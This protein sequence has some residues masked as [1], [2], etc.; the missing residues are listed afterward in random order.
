MLDPW[1]MVH[2]E[3][4]APDCRYALLVV[5]VV[6]LAGTVLFRRLRKSTASVGEAPPREGAP[7]DPRVL[8]ALGAAFAVDW[9]LWL[10]G[11]GNSRYFLPLACVAGVL[12]MGMLFNLFS[13]RPKVRNYVLAAIF[14]SQAL[15][16][17]WGAE[18]RWAAGSWE[19]KWFEVTVPEALAKQPALYL[20]MEVRSNSFL[21]PYLP[22]EAGL[23]DIASS[24]PLEGTGAIGRRV[25]ALIHRYGTHVRLLISGDRLH[26]D[27]ERRS[28]TVSGVNSTL[29]R[30]GLRVDPG[31]CSKLAVQDLASGP[32]YV[33][34]SRASP[35]STT[36]SDATLYLVSCALV[37]DV[38]D[39][40]EDIARERTANIVLDRLEDA[41]PKLFQPRRMPTGRY[42]NLWRRIYLNTDL[43]AWV[44]RGEVKFFDPVHGDDTVYLGSE[45]AWAQAAPRL[46]CTRR[47]GHYF[48]KVVPDASPGH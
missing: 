19:G 33:S 31:D 42:G 35:V 10:M 3:L 21:A 28:P 46:A 37:P 13:T 18:L 4:R 5:L 17:W 44:S 15:Q 24:Y 2:E 12:V 16:V 39:H 7:A 29:Q 1:N 47:Q 38:T 30:F 9:V 14:A 48:A 6:L 26:A 11:S 20:T 36:D 41:C 8:A 23:V 32:V 27:G 45:N 34:S 22:P 43:V 25:Q 40:P